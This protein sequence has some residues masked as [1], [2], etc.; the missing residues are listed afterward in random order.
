MVDRHEWD[1]KAFVDFYAILLI[2]PWAAFG[3]TAAA[4]AACTEEPAWGYFGSAAIT[5]GSASM[6]S[7]PRRSDPERLKFLSDASD[8]VC[9]RRKSGL[10][11]LNRG[12]AAMRSSST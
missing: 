3:P 2:T 8:R 9:L 7:Q 11:E 1:A 4:P 12:E 5:P 6:R 10:D